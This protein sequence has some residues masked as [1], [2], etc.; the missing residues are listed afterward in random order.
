MAVFL[1]SILFSCDSTH[2]HG[3]ALLALSPLYAKPSNRI[4]LSLRSIRMKTLFG[5]HQGKEVYKV[6]MR[7]GKNHEVSVINYGTIITNYIVPDKSGKATDIVLGFDSLEPYTGAHP[8]FGATIGRFANRI[9]GASFTIDN[10]SHSISANEGPNSLHSGPSGLDRKVWDIVSES[11]NE[12]RFSCLSPDGDEGFPGNC[13]FELTMRLDENSLTMD[14]TAT[15]DKPTHVNLTNHSYFNLNGEGIATVE[16]HLF[17][18]FSEKIT[19][20]DSESIPTGNIL[21]VDGGFYDLR[22]RSRLSDKLAAFNGMDYDINYILD[23]GYAK[24][25]EAFSEKTGITMT[26]FTDQ[27]GVQFYSG[28]FLDDVKGKSGHNYPKH[29]GF[30]FEPQRWPDAPNKAGFPSTL[31]RPGEIY[32][33]KSAFVIS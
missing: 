1:F 11:E 20:N 32:R 30:C 3:A 5:T 31:L 33:Q 22:S 13:K 26:L 12:V 18:V 2:Q 7:N 4:I 29:G 9:G 16:D 23:N 8:Y 19:E 25:A 6:V 24:A 17:T 15:T 27:P 21:P 28:I 14:Y 10:V